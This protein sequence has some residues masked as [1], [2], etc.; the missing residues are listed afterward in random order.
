M[1]TEETPLEDQDAEEPTEETED[2]EVALSKKAFDLAAVI[3]AEVLTGLLG[4]VDLRFPSDLAT[5]EKATG[6]KKKKVKRKKSGECSKHNEI[7]LKKECLTQKISTLNAETLKIFDWI[8]L[9][10]H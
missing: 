6:K 10:F 9:S 8:R 3:H 4:D 1:Q 5:Q 7:N 2:E